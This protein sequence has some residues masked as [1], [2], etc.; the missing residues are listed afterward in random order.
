MRTRLISKILIIFIIVFGLIVG[1][2]HFSFS[3][4]NSNRNEKKVKTVE[5]NIALFSKIKKGMTEEEVYD[6]LGFKPTKT[7]G[8]G[9]P[10]D[11]YELGK[12]ISGKIWWIKGKVIS[13]VL[14]EKILIE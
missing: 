7:G 9:V 4:K 3:S 2:Q 5:E 10:T 14:G 1:C 13:V 6:L 8:Y 11:I 12:N